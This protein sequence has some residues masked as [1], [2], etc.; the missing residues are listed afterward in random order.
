M[1]RCISV[2]TFEKFVVKLETFL[3]LNELNKKLNCVKVDNT[4]CSKSDTDEE[5]T[6]VSVLSD[7]NVVTGTQ[8]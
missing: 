5:E 8:T 4:V 6:V 3:C 1:Y 7:S 2:K